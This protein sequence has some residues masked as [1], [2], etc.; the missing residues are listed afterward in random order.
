MPYNHPY[1]QPLR[2]T[3]VYKRTANGTAHAHK[4][5]CASGDI[6]SNAF[7]CAVDIGEVEYV[8]FRT[9]LAVRTDVNN[10]VRRR[11]HHIVNV[12]FKLRPSATVRLFAC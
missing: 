10:Q 5:L 7:A 1:K 9:V 8:A 6:R 2:W 12:Q 4:K 11:I 3:I